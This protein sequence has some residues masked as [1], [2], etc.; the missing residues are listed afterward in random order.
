MQIIFK[1]HLNLLMQPSEVTDLLSKTN[2]K[3]A[4][5]AP[6]IPFSL[7]LRATI[8]HAQLSHRSHRRRRSPHRA[9][10]DRRSNNQSPTILHSL[11]SSIPF[12]PSLPLALAAAHKGKLCSRSSS[13]IETG[14]LCCYYY[15]CCCYYSPSSSPY[16]SPPP[17]RGILRAHPWRPPH[18]RRRCCCCTALVYA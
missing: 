6:T 16:L 15:Y 17:P 18:H 8:P 2:L 11:Y 7:N 4:T 5:P 9:L 1:N 10:K 14:C 3:T 12:H 13:S